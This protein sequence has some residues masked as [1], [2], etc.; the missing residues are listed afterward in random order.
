M[1]ART[2]NATL[3]GVGKDDIDHGAIE[4]VVR[5]GTDLAHQTSAFVLLDAVRRLDAGL[6]LP[7]YDAQFFSAAARCASVSV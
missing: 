3:K 7:V 1:P 6:P 4:T 5:D 2:I